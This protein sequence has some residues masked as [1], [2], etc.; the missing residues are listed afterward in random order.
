M[1]DVPPCA[2]VRRFDAQISDFDDGDEANTFNRKMPSYTLADI[3][4]SHE[5]RGWQ[6]DAAVAMTSPAGVH[7]TLF[8]MSLGLA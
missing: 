4:L 2:Q 1:R 7:F 5:Y 6:F 8:Q 3:K